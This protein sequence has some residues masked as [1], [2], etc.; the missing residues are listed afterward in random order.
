MTEAI[1]THYTYKSHKVWYVMNIL[2]QGQQWTTRRRYSDFVIL[3]KKLKKEGYFVEGELPCKVIFGMFYQ[4]V[5]DSRLKELNRYLRLLNANISSDNTYLREFYE[6]DEN[7]LKYAL[8]MNKKLSD[9]QRAENIRKIF[10]EASMMMIN[11]NSL[12]IR[13]RNRK[14][15][16]N[17][18]QATVLSG[19]YRRG[20]AMFSSQSSSPRWKMQ[21]Q[22]PRSP[23]RGKEKKKVASVNNQ[24]VSTSKHHDSFSSNN[25]SS[26]N[27]SNIDSSI[28]D[29]TGLDSWQ[30]SEVVAALRDSFISNANMI[31]SQGIVCDSAI[32]ETIKR[33]DFDCVHNI[34]SCFRKQSEDGKW[35]EISDERKIVDC[36]SLSSL[37]DVSQMLHEMKNIASVVEK[38]QQVVFKVDDIVVDPKPRWRSE[39]KES[40]HCSPKRSPKPPHHR[41]PGQESTI[42][43]RIRFSANENVSNIPPH[44]IKH[45]L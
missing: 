13:S 31:A 12:R 20:T 25:E 28:Y 33:Q 6:V 39:L 37:P 19:L 7:M 8:K 32:S 24:D 5:L 18:A 30:D 36:L 42:P 10:Q 9:V 11:V 45:L 35:T 15:F 27:G 34:K 21:P 14:A 43:L 40:L 1:I 17:Q 4:S 2:Y 16:Y 23:Q 29:S 26:W 44:T 22:I 3:D 38:Y 41:P